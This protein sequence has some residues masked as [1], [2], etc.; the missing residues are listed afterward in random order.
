MKRV[1]WLLA[2]VC[3]P[4]IAAAQ[5][6]TLA[7]EATHGTANILVHYAT[8]GTDVPPPAD[9]NGDGVPDFVAEVAAEAQ[10]AYTR[11]GE[12][13]FAAPLA[14]A[15]GGDA[16]VDIYLRDLISADGNAGTDSCANNTCI[17]F[18]VAENDFE[19]YGYASRTEGIRSVV[20]HELFHLVQYAYA[21]GQ[22]TTFTEGTAVWAV[23][24]LYGDGCT[25][26]ER[27]VPGFLSKTFRPFER[28]GT[29][30]G[31]NYPYGAALFWNFLSERFGP[32]VIADGWEAARTA[33]ALDAIH[34]ALGARDTTLDDVWVEFTR[35]NATRTPLP[36]RE[37][38]N[39]T[40]I[41]IEGLSAR[42]I[43]IELATP[44]HLSFATTSRIRVAANDLELAD[45]TVLQPGAYLLTVTGLSRM[46][47]ATVVDITYGPPPEEPADGG[48]CSA[49]PKPRPSFVVAF[50]LLALL[51]ALTP[52]HRTRPR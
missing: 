1:A 36:P 28:G 22:P 50:V 2:L 18:A 49:A 4:A 37:P 45:D 27:F 16:R 8:T 52:R 39:A 29:G 30:F 31:D 34:T 13:G 20:P 44:T 35:E 41:Y 48:G 23:E 25:D 14:D 46:T 11:F 21:M 17:G 3:G 7:N 40:K 43:P 32:E 26:Y 33:P 24:M 38:A 19:N 10:L 12:I 6:P 9:T 15:L 5:R 51:V 42:Y 47:I